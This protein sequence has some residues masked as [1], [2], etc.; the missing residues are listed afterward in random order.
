MPETLIQLV[1]RCEE[2]EGP[3]RELDGDIHEALF[4]AKRGKE[5][6]FS[7]AVAEERYYTHPETGFGMLSPFA[8]TASVEA[9]EK[10]LPGPEWPEWQITRR[11]CT[12]YHANV[13]MGDDGT[14]CETPA[15]ALTAAALRARASLKENSRGLIER[16]R[17]KTTRDYGQGYRS[18]AS[19][20]INPDGPEAA[21]RIEQQ[22]ARIAELEKAL[23]GLLLH[24]NED[25]LHVGCV[26]N[27]REHVQVA[28]QALCRASIEGEGRNEA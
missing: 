2:A 19:L 6:G 1:E 26:G 11:Y 14:G 23:S 13:G 20:L 8:F 28:R 25:C 5:C 17:A 3:D 18:P 16:L 12:G 9:A 24:F 22:Q 4:G 15:L 7:P 21:D 10:A 27:Q